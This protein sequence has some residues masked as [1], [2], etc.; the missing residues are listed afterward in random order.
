[1]PKVFSVNWFRKDEAGKFMWPGYGENM[2]V[3]KWIFERVHGRA[4]GEKNILGTSP[5]Y[6]DLDWTGLES[7]NRQTFESLTNIAGQGWIEE[8]ANH[9]EALAKYGSH[10]PPE[11]IAC[12]ELLTIRASE[13]AAM[14]MAASSDS[15]KSEV[16]PEL[17]VQAAR[18]AAGRG[19]QASART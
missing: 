18:T 10:M 13:F 8:A 6:E 1:L 12:N 16:S 3:L 2:R 17:L 14:Q 9:R 4:G 19:E 11:M 5:R 15:S 7:F